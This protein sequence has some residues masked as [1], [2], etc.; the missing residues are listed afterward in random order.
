[1]TTHTREESFAYPVARA[2]EAQQAEVDA[3]SAKAQTPAEDPAAVANPADAPVGPTDAAKPVEP[4]EAMPR[5]KPTASE[6]VHPM[7]VSEEE[8][9]FSVIQED[10]I[11]QLNKIL[12]LKYTGIILYTNYGDRLLAHWRDSVAD[13]FTDHMKDERKGAYA[14]VRKITALGGAP[15]PKVAP[16]RSVDDFHGMLMELMTAEKDLIKEARALVEM[17]GENVGLRVMAEDLVVTDAHH[18]DDLRRLLMCENF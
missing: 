17:A 11:K 2:A 18:L 16:M 9:F 4:D 6:G 12:K 10:V 5:P 8:G 7:M 3:A 13:H 14:I 1:M 15:D